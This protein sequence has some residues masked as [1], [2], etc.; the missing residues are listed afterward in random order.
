MHLE[1]YIPADGLKPFIKTFMVIESD[2][3]MDNRILPGTSIVMVL[4]VRGNVLLKEENTTTGLPASLITGIRQSA[5][6]MTYSKDTVT[7]LVIFKETGAAAFFRQPLHELQGLSVSLDHLIP[8]QRIWDIEEQLYSAPTHPQ[9][10]AIVQGFLLSILHES[11]PDL[12]IRSAVQKIAQAHGNIRIMDL[13]K[14]LYT[15]RD[16]FEKRFRQATGTSPKQFAG[17]VRLR[18]LI[19]NYPNNKNLTDAAHMAGYFDQAHFNKHF[20]SF[21][22]QTPQDF[23]RSTPHW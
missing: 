20:R 6:V 7:I 11:S 18:H 2:G 9:R 22:G 13:A 10:I 8:P 4:R 5:R 15:S 23:F 14:G 3:G 17:I 12:L 1:K 21:T 19:S 16:P